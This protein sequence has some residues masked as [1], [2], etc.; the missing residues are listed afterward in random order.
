MAVPSCS[1]MVKQSPGTSKGSLITAGSEKSPPG[2]ERSSKA[3]SVSEWAHHRLSVAWIPETC[4][5]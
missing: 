3:T 1:T 4:S 2:G 5:R